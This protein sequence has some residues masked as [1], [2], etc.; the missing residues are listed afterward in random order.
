MP[1]I[2]A[3][4]TCKRVDVACVFSLVYC[5]SDTRKSAMIRRLLLA[6]PLALL[7][8]C[9]DGKDGTSIT[10]NAD[11]ADGNVVASI[12]SNGQLALNAPGIS[13]SIKL[14][15]I[16]L[17][18]DNFDMNG[19]HLYPGSTISGMNID[20]HDR[21]GHDD[22]GQVKVSFESP[23]TPAT[24]RDW[25]AGKLGGAGFK[26]SPNG[27]GLAGTT[28]E[29]KPFRLDLSPEGADKARGTIL[30]G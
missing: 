19:V 25:F 15:A 3:P 18:A 17:D 20:G 9:G 26:V 14:P 21:P 22:D 27:S 10:L 30:I 23:A 11:G 6:I 12:G 2:A 8:A 1:D 4:V 28:E 5:I 16:K 29:G 7:A 24:V 13:G